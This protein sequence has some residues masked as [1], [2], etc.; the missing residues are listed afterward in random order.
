VSEKGGAD[1]FVAPVNSA[2]VP[3]LAAIAGSPVGTLG[4]AVGAWIAARHQD[5]RDSLGK[6]IARRVALYSDFIGESARMRL[7]ANKPT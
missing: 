1:M 3:V 2:M 4:S 6:Q 5:R 7:D